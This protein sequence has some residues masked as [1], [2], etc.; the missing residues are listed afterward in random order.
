MSGRSMKFRKVI[1][2]FVDVAVSSVAIVICALAAIASVLILGW[3]ES[4]EVA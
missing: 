3:G 2:G 4:E 1:I